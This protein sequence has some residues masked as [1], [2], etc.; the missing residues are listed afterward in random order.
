MEAAAAGLSLGSDD[1]A[2]HDVVMLIERYPAD[3]FAAGA[4]APRLADIAAACDVGVR[5]YCKT[6]GMN[7][8]DG[9]EGSSDGQ[10]GRRGVEDVYI[11][12]G[13]IGDTVMRFVEQCMATEGLVEGNSLQARPSHCSVSLLFAH[14][15]YYFTFSHLDRSHR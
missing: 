1:M 2:V 12:A 13:G 3:P 10:E 9:G 11:L 5:V 6:G 14:T 15:V 7:E 8:G 4:V